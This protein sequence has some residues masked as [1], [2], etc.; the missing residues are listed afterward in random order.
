MMVGAGVGW[1]LAFSVT[2]PLK[3][4]DL[5]RDAAGDE[6]LLLDSL[7]H[8]L[9]VWVLITLGLA[10][11]FV[12]L[13]LGP[14]ATLIPSGWV[15]RYPRIATAGLPGLFLLPLGYRM[16]T[17]A[18]MQPGP[19]EFPGPIYADYTVFILVFFTVASVIYLRLVRR[20]MRVPAA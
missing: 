15:V 14:L 3:I 10:G 2:V 4:A 18:A 11:A 5:V 9:I 20:G 1:L 19:Y 6:R 7:T 17:W 8:G 12:V 13:L 16:I